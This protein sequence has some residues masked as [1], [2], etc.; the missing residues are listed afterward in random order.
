MAVHA[1]AG[2]NETARTG[3]L[4]E[5]G[6]DSPCLSDIITSGFL[7]KVLVPRHLGTGARH[8]GKDMPRASLPY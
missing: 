3:S 1:S 2:F 4:P 7:E 6:T 5:D 8:P